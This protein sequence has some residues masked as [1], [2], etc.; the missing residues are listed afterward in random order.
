MPNLIVIEIIMI[1]YAFST[2][3]LVGTMM[4]GYV[5]WRRDIAKKIHTQLG[6]CLREG[7]QPLADFKEP[8]ANVEKFIVHENCIIER[9]GGKFYI[10]KP[11]GKILKK[12]F[13]TV[14]GAK[15]E[16]DIIAPLLPKR[17]DT[18]QTIQNVRFVK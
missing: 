17:S 7:T 3:F 8:T 1:I 5:I 2:S 12:E 16:I 6:A 11:S 4:L 10:I 15:E 18:R 9:R 14:E 13:D